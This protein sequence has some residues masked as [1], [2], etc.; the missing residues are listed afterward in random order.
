MEHPSL[1]GSPTAVLS[2]PYGPSLAL[3]VPH[4]HGHERRTLSR[5]LVY[6]YDLSG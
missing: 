4:G 3:V 2:T 1:S 5:A 6:L